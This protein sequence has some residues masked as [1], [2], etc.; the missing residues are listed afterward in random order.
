M[1]NAGRAPN[2]LSAA[3][4]T[5]PFAA[6]TAAFAVSVISYERCDTRLPCYSGQGARAGQR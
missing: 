5:A 4:N 3:K 1:I 2:A 6:T